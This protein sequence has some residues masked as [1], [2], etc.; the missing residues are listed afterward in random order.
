[1][2]ILALTLVLTLLSA[3]ELIA[4][5]AVSFRKEVLPILAENCF[6]CHGPDENTREA[7][8]RLD[9]SEDA[10]KLRG[11]YQVINPGHVSESELIRRIVTKDESVKMPPADFD[12]HLT[13]DQIATLKNWIAN[14]AAYEQHWS[15]T[16]I[17][18]PGLP[19]VNKR[20]QRWMR[21]PIDTFV[22]SRLEDARVPASPEAVARTLARRLAIDITGLPPA[23]AAVN[24]FVEHYDPSN[25]DD[26]AYLEY[27]DQLLDSPHYG[28]RMAM[29]W[30]DAARYSD[31][32]GYQSDSTRNNWPWKDWV[33]NAFNSNMPYDQFT[34]EQFAGDLLP[35]ATAEQQ[36]ATCFHRNHMANGEGGRHPEE[37]RIEYVID[38]VNTTGTV[39]LGITLGCSQC[40]S[41]KYDP[42]SHQ[43]YYQMF[44]FFN[45][46]EEDGKAGG[47]AK[48]FLNYKPSTVEP[49]IDSTQALV[50]LRLKAEREEYAR[51]NTRFENWLAKTVA[52]LPED[53]QAWRP[54]TPTDLSTAYG[55]RLTSNDD[56]LILADDK[57]PHH[58]D[59][60]LTGRPNLNRITG[61]R[62]EVPPTDDHTNGAYSHS[63]SGH[64]ILT[65]VKLRVVSTAT[66]TVRD[67]KFAQAIADHQADRGKYNGYGL[68]AHILDDDPRNG[69]ASFDSDI[70]TARTAI[71]AL[72][73]PLVLAP[74]ESLY[75]ELQQRSLQGAHNLGAF[76]ISLTDQVG[77]AVRSLNPAP[78]Q[79][80]ANAAP[81]SAADIDNGLRAELLQQ[82]LIDDIAYQRVKIPLNEAQGQLSE[83]KSAAG[84]KRVMV[85]AERPEPRTSHILLRGVWDAKGDEVNSGVPPVLGALPEG[86]PNNRLGLAKWLV[87]RDNPLTARV[88]VNH[89]WRLI[90]GKGLVRTAEDFGIQGELPTHPELLDWLA[91][92]LIENDWNLKSLIR[93]IVQSATYRQSSNLGD[94]PRKLLEKDPENRLLARAE[95]FRMPAW[96]IRDSVLQASQL[97]DT[98]VGGPPVR[99]YQPS[100]V[101]ADITMGRFKYK[102]SQGDA[103]FR[104][105]VYTFWRRSAAPAFLFDNAKRRV[106]QVTTPITNT[107]L[108]ALTLMNDLTYLESSRVLAQNAATAFTTRPEQINYIY[109]HLLSRRPHK[110]ELDVI[111]T[112]LDALE[113]FYRS[114]PEQAR[115]YLRHGQPES[116]PTFAK[117]GTT[118]GQQNATSLAALSSITSMVMNLDET[119]TRE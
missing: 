4:A 2:R 71:L 67:I 25:P 105:T 90:I 20:T 81:Q 108:H 5:P 18:R 45:S 94:D 77:T 19:Q 61:V 72:E 31:T 64:F 3:V 11:D 46:I 1:M 66:S 55:T 30:L 56:G 53:Y 104:R 42:I 110:A 62:I 109:E 70:K 114:N 37:S 68:V 86:V 14:G 95:R 51:A 69:W 40:H 6:Q 119:I 116:I 29:F 93:Q 106:C 16:R 102:P 59:Y 73:T 7:D 100:G 63:D 17:E 97:L 48:P 21:N 98:T 112:Q 87:D 101:W 50:E 65:D 15:F 36:L 103:Q 80:L 33:I 26:T 111:L 47:G 79:K 32:D 22:G 96:M 13:N 76:R 115:R 92:E 113:V 24:K 75:L 44:S 10:F 74:E 12:K 107:P 85:L 34:I 89:V 57:N 60:Q 118:T 38:R 58:E 23:P 49:H 82:F 28:E 117:W 88:T 39:W 99:P 52:D 27:V 9:N 54:F 78:L 41:H 35:N 43:S 8:L 84:D 83:F 91:V